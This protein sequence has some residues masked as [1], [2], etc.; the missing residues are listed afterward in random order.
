MMI[1]WTP[2]GYARIKITSPMIDRAVDK[3]NLLEG[4]PDVLAQDI[5]FDEFDA[6]Y[7]VYDEV[8]ASITNVAFMIGHASKLRLAKMDEAEL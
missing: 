4:H 6:L 1:K 7:K 5:Y 2:Q 8:V 3:S